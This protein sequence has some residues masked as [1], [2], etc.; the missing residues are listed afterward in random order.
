M[1]VNDP[2]GDRKPKPCS[3]IAAGFVRTVK[4]LEHMGNIFGRHTDPGIL[5]FQI[6]LS[7]IS[8]PGTK[9]DLGSFGGIFGTVINK[10]THSLF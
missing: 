2:P 1:P 9:K 8:L 3:L 5:Y 10:N 7:I 4:T 6:R